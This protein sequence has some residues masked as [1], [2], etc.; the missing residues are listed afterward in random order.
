MQRFTLMTLSFALLAAGAAE[1]ANWR[2]KLLRDLAKTAT[3]FDA[4]MQSPSSDPSP[5]WGSAVR[6]VTDE[7]GMTTM[8][9]VL[10]SCTQ[11]LTYKDVSASG[12]FS[13]VVKSSLTVGAG[14]SIDVVDIGGGY[15][16]TQVAGLEYHL[17]GKRILDPASV[18]E[19]RRCCLVNPDQCQQEVITEWWKGQGAYYTLSNAAA[20]A[21]IAVKNVKYAP[22]ANVDW[23]RGWGVSMKWPS[24]GSECPVFPNA[25]WKECGEFFAY[26][27]QAIQVPTCQQ[28]M[29]DTPEK[30]GFTLFSGVSEWQQSESLARAKA[31]EDVM[32]QVAAY[33]GTDVAGSFDG[34]SLSFGDRVFA[35]ADG[36]A[37]Q[38]REDAG[39]T[40]KYL[41]RNRV[42]VADSTLQ[43]CLDRKSLPGTPPATT[44]KPGTP[45]S[46]KPTP[47]ETPATPPADPPADK[48]PAETPAPAEKLPPVK[49][50]VQGPAPAPKP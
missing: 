35:T 36:F 16:N 22:S 45:P 17:S 37:C 14:M 30:A 49:V 4:V 13:K 28:Y 21:K 9:V 39:G 40:M 2:A 31:R 38:D 33:C 1:A 18:D 20:Q 42:W 26:R 11:E 50:P 7:R 3:A 32:K 23:S 19:Y 27:T 10:S 25:G 24:E 43:Q 41:G 8:D 15:Q 46:S 29:Q 6:R 5:S 44:G 34:A 48:A 12:D 47:A